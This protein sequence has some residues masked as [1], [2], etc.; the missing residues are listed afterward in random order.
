MKNIVWILNLNSLLKLCTVNFLGI[1][2]QFNI[3]F[4]LILM[5]TFLTAISMSAIAT[6]GVVPGKLKPLKTVHV[7]SLVSGQIAASIQN[8]TSPQTPVLKYVAPITF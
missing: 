6:N 4:F 8:I 5:Q 3:S 1:S 2:S 7:Q